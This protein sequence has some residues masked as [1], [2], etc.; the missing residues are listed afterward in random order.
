MY[1]IQ[2]LLIPCLTVMGSFL[3]CAMIVIPM[4]LWVRTETKQENWDMESKLNQTMDATR[5][6]VRILHDESKELLKRVH[7][8]ENRKK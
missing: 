4:F 1:D 2:D 8:L 3:A 6:H 7:E 5:Q